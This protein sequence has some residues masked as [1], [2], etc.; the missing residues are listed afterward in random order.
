MRLLLSSLC[1]SPLLKSHLQPSSSLF[2]LPSSSLASSSSSSTRSF[3]TSTPLSIIGVGNIRRPKRA[4]K[5]HVRVGRGQGQGT[6]EG[7]GNGTKGQNSR[8][9]QGTYLAFEGGQTPVTLQYPKRG[10][11]NYNRKFYQPLNLRTLQEYIDLRRLDASEPI[12][13]E[14]IH[15]SN[16]VRGWK[17]ANGFKLLAR[18]FENITQPIHIFPHRAS[19]RAI[20]A[21]EAAGGSVTCVYHNRLSFRQAIHPERFLGPK[22]V[23]EALPLKKRD[24]LYYTNWEKRGYLADKPADWKPSTTFDINAVG[25]PRGPRRHEPKHVTKAKSIKKDVEK[26]QR[27]PTVA[28]GRA[29][30]DW[31]SRPTDATV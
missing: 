4:H 11:F 19:L 29:G 2:N 24:I 8:A 3:T 10:F 15:N 7:K 14:H 1:S 16:M 30:D 28:V 20:A 31:D 26:V 25:G 17:S 9:G 18:G 23:K 13:V 21:I 27:L 5:I 22:R 12:T 6:G